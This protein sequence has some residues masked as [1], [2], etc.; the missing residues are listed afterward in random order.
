M[1]ETKAPAKA[2]FRVI[3]SN[4]LNHEVGDEIMLT[5]RQAKALVNKVERVA[6]PKAAKKAESKPAE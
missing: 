1:A 4:T 2:K 5:A 3:R 6:K